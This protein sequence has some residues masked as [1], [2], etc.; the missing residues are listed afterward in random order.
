MLSCINVY[1][2]IEDVNWL[3]LLPN[4]SYSVRLYPLHEIDTDDFFPT[5]LLGSIS[6]THKFIRLINTLHMIF[7]YR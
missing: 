2:C 5:F 3:Y 7:K 1:F 6:Q 4:I